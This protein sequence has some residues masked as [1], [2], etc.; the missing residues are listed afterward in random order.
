MGRQYKKWVSVPPCITLTNYHYKNFR[1]YRSWEDTR[2]KD[3][4]DK[5]SCCLGLNCAGCHRPNLHRETQCPRKDIT[6]DSEALSWESTGFNELWHPTIEE[7]EIM[8]PARENSILLY[9]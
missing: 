2:Y 8:D 4:E 3:L 7:V 9:N 6:L 5:E 1:I